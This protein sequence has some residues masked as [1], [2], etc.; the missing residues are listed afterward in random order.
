VSNERH[1]AGLV[2]RLSVLAGG[3]AVL[4]QQGIGLD[5]EARAMDRIGWAATRLQ[6]ILLRLYRLQQRHRQRQ[7]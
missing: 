4:E 6:R 5:L 3:S 1:H 2:T 7:Q